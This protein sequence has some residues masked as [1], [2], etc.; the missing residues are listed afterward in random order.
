V[1]KILLAVLA[2]GTVGSTMELILL[3]HTE[4]WRPWIPLILLVAALIARRGI[5]QK[6]VAR[7]ERYVTLN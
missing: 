4:D 6:E 1:R 2:L 7:L 3:A 5:D